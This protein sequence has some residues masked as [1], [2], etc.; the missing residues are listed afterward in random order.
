MDRL[1]RR[2]GYLAML[3]VLAA[4]TAASAGCVNLLTGALYLIKGTNAPA[5][6]SLKG[7]KVCVVCRC[8]GSMQYQNITVTR[9]L[10]REI[11]KLLR[12]NVGRIEVTDQR[13]VETWM[14]ENQWDEFDEV[15]KAMKVEYVIGIDL[16]HFSLY[17]GQTLFQGNAGAELKV[18][19]VATGE[20]AYEKSMPQM[21]YPPNAVMTTGEIQE[22]EFRSKYLKILADQ[23]ARHFYPHDT[24]ADYALDATIDD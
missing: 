18:I 6:Y 5:D 12:Q 23:L 9:D 20:V 13:T 15:G 14:D 2:L 17:Q 4:L 7:K 10:A 16:E 19:D 11:T 1:R 22:S 21:K 8:V 24:Y 3:V